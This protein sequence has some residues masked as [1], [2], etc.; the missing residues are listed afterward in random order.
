MGQLPDEITVGPVHAMT[1]RILYPFTDTLPPHP[2]PGAIFRQVDDGIAYAQLVREFWGTDWDLIIVEH[3][4]DVPAT[5]L[6]QLAMLDT[7]GCAPYL[8]RPAS[9]GHPR[10]VFSSWS[11][12]ADRSRLVPDMPNEPWSAVAALGA[13]FIPAQHLSRSFPLPLVCDSGAYGLPHWSRVDRWVNDHV[14]RHDQSDRPWRNIW[15]P[16]AVH[17]GVET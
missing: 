13:T 10:P 2:I 12:N 4:V 1:L 8:L 11:Y 16:A 6:L 14:R 15:E 17:L 7:P 9:T 3:D 5:T